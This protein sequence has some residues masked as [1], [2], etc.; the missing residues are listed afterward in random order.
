MA[1]MSVTLTMRLLTKS[2]EPLSRESQLWL[3]VGKYG[4]LIETQRIIKSALPVKK[5]MRVL[6]NSEVE[7]TIPPESEQEPDLLNAIWETQFEYCDV[8]G[9]Q[10][11][12]IVTLSTGKLYF[13]AHHFKQN[14]KVLYE[15]AE[16]IID[17]SNM[18]LVR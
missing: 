4:C 6:M 18:L 8:C 17:E 5:S 11:Y 13:C 1:T 3:C 12:Y 16:D 7:A 14:K 2:P 10:S 15:I 9:Y